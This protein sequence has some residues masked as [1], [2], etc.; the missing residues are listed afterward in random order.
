MALQSLNLS[1]RTDDQGGDVRPFPQMDQ[2]YQNWSKSRLVLLIHG[3]NNPVPD[4]RKAYDG[5][6]SLQQQLGGYPI[7]GNFA[8]DR[9]FVEVF[10]KGDDWGVLS[11]LYYPYAIPS[12]G[13]TA[14]ALAVVLEN[15]AQQRAE[16]LELEVVAHS[17][18]TRLTLDLL[19][20]ISTVPRITVTRI[21]FFAAATPTFMLEESAALR[22]AYDTGV[23]GGLLSLYSGND[24]VLS[25]A[26]PLGQTVAPG[27]EGFFPTALGHALWRPPDVPPTLGQEENRNANHGDYWGCGKN[28]TECE[29]FANMK[30]RD[31]LGFAGAGDR[32]PVEA[33]TAERDINEAIGVPERSVPSREVAVRPD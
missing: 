10:W 17:L 30:A 1:F 15:L 11:L 19:R 18:G 31:Y 21:V 29:R 26:F 8:P 9:N 22:Q 25:W 28:R 3:Y 4:A 33:M 20:E 16:G 24:I 14:E 5:F 13:Q 7:G 32:I 12:A 2:F 23:K 6:F 27:Q